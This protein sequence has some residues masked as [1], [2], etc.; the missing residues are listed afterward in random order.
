[1]SY[2]EEFYQTQKPQ[3]I[4]EGFEYQILEQSTHEKWVRRYPKFSSVLEDQF[5]GPLIKEKTLFYKCPAYFI[6]P[7]DLKKWLHK[8][9]SNIQYKN[10]VVTKIVKNNEAYQVETLDENILADKVIL[11]TN[12]LTPLLSKDISEEFQFYLN[13]CKPVSGSYLELN[14]VSRFGIEFNSTFNLAIEKYHFIYRHD[15]DQ[16]QIGATSNNR[17]TC[18]IPKTQQ[19]QDIYSFIDRY[20]QF[21]LPR[22]EEFTEKSGI[23]FKGYYRLPFWGKID[24]SNLYTVCGLYKNA[25]TYAFRAAEDLKLDLLN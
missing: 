2:F 24:D 9:I 3:G 18:E 14:Q 8:G 10:K 6:N 15:I 17:D 12:H 16:I 7:N 5:L 22:Y 20:T 19:L 25:F 13:H 4:I 11:C 1:M 23:R 21:K